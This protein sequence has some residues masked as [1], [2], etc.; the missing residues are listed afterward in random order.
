LNQIIYLATYNLIN[1]ILWARSNKLAAGGLFC[2][3]TKAFDCVNH[4]VLLA[5]LE[6]HGINGMAGS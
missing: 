4:E 2:N 3:L 6:F 1:N 5:K